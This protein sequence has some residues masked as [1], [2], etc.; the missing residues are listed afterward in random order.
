MVGKS[1]RESRIRT[2]GRISRVSH[3][4]ARPHSFPCSPG[5]HG[6]RDQNRSGGRT[7]SRN[8]RPSCTCTSGTSLGVLKQIEAPIFSGV[9]RENSRLSISGPQKIKTSTPLEQMVH[10]AARLSHN[11]TGK[12]PINVPFGNPGGDFF[13][14]HFPLNVFF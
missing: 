2:Q 5:S 1:T 4:S 14:R 12:V 7:G 11:V 10:I 8:R 13:I 6:N 9:C 3:P